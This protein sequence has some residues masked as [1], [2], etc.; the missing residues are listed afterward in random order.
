MSQIQELRTS[1]C[2]KAETIDTL[3]QEL[4]DIN[5]SSVTKKIINLN[6]THIHRLLKGL[7]NVP[8]EEKI[9]CLSKFGN[10]S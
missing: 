6:V 8:A 7:T 1:S 3:K 2:E 9:L 10:R 4:K 5:V